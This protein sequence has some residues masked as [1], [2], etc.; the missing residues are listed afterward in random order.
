MIIKGLYQCFCHA[1][2]NNQSFPSKGITIYKK[3]LND[4]T[5]KIIAQ[6]AT[7]DPQGHYGRSSELSQ[8]LSL[9]MNDV[10]WMEVSGNQFQRKDEFTCSFNLIFLKAGSFV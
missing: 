7:Y 6:V 3:V 4:T 1:H 9:D 8:L 10:I 2:T 5:E